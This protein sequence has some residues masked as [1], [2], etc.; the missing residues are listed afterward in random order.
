MANALIET[1][2]RLRRENAEMA[3]VTAEQERTILELRGEVSRLKVIN[4]NLSRQVKKE[5]S[6]V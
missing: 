1:V 2:S 5:P 3:K 4:T 6:D